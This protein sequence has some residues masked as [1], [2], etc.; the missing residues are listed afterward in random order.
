[1][2]NKKIFYRFHLPASSPPFLEQ[3]HF[4]T[5]TGILLHLVSFIL[6][7]VLFFSLMLIFDRH[8]TIARIIVNFF[9]WLQLSFF[10][11]TVVTFIKPFTMFIC[12]AVF[13]VFRKL[14]HVIITWLAVLSEVLYRFFPKIF[15]FF[16]NINSEIFFR[17]F[18]GLWDNLL[19]KSIVILAVAPVQLVIEIGFLIW[20]TTAAPLFDMLRSMLLG[21]LA[22]LDFIWHGV[23]IKYDLT[24]AE[25]K[26]II[27]KGKKEGLTEAQIRERLAAKR[28]ELKEEED[29]KK[30][31]GL[32]KEE[33][34][35][36]DVKVDLSK[37][38][39]IVV[40]GIG[41][42]VLGFIKFLEPK[43]PLIW[44]G[45]KLS[46]QKISGS[47]I[48]RG[49][50]LP[51]QKIS[52]SIICRGIPIIVTALG[53]ASIGCI[54]YPVDMKVKLYWTFLGFVNDLVDVLSNILISNICF[55]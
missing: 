30:K 31:E 38:S 54:I 9:E 3:R 52:G 44:K 42:T 22:W 13:L 15:P 17:K 18:F 29:K 33:D 19:L 2:S 16:E 6:F 49:L 8:V 24:E 25:I 53:A 36:E 51:D 12:D 4:L 27:E 47:F 55:L 35:K 23:E 21:V 32:I 39:N 28:E 45:P 34:K 40:T 7:T 46:D 10:F 14:S 37:T 5:I 43:G 50:E 41:A 1:M 48:C 11:H 20:D 26:E